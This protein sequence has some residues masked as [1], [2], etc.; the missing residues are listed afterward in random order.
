MGAAPRGGLGGRAEWLRGGLGR[1]A[2]G[3][4]GDGMRSGARGQRYYAVPCVPR[5]R[6]LRVNRGLCVNLA[7]R[8][9]PGDCSLRL[10]NAG[11]TLHVLATKVHLG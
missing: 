11:M 3:V 8:V 9:L 7:Q 6:G 5:R 4:H 1:A 2:C 10:L